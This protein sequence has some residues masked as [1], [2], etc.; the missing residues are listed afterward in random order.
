L[1][2]EISDQ[3]D[4]GDD[5]ETGPPADMI[6]QPRARR[7]AKDRAEIDAC[8][9]DRETCVPPLVAG[10]VQGSDNGRDVRFEE[11]IADHD[12]AER[13]KQQRRVQR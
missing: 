7:L 13:G 4:K 9:E 12:Q 1:H 8:V 10:S 2:Q 11:A 5:Q 6:D 3:Q